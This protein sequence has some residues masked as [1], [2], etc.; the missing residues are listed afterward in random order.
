MR[1]GHQPSSAPFGFRVSGFGFRIPGFAQRVA[2]ALTRC[3]EGGV[4]LRVEG[5]GFRIWQHV[6]IG[7]T[8]LLALISSD[9]TL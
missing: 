8:G 2:V 5:L 6:A 7:T 1:A 3:N 9:A 4:G